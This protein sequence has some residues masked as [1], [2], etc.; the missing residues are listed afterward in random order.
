MNDL[1]RF[2]VAKR[3]EL[4]RLN[5]GKVEIDTVHFFQLFRTVC[6]MSHIHNIVCDEVDMVEAFRKIQEKEC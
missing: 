1:Y 5:R 3:D 6:D 2:M 4:Y